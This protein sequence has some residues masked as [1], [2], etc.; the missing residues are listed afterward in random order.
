[1]LII[2]QGLAGTCLAWRLH[3]RGIPFLVVDRHE[4]LTSSKVAAGLVT[5]V[6]GMRLN[7]N[8]R[9]PEL[10]EEAVGLYRAL[11]PMLGA[12]FYHEAPIVRLL[13]DEKA[14]ALWEKRRVEPQI[15]PFLEQAGPGPLVDEARFHQPWGGFQM[16]HS[17]WLDAAGFVEASRQFFAACGSWQRGEVLPGE[18]DVQ[19]HAVEWAGRSFEAAV[20][21]IG[22]EAARHPWFDWVPF[23]SAQGTVLKLRADTGGENRILN[24]GC[25]LLPH[26][27]GLLRAGPTYDLKFKS[28]CEPA[29]DTVA[30][31]ED[32]LRGLFKGSWE[33]LG[34]QT[35]VRPIIQGRKALLGRHPARRRVAFLNGLG[36]KGVLRAPWAARVLVEHLLDG[37]PLDAGL[38]LAT[39]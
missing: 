8:W 10:H 30:A 33:V 22:W 24:R 27:D 39:A 35:G 14:A 3:Q 5:P 11:E 7:L 17:G 12:R 31:L 16:R 29:P 1:M 25:W 23:R 19:P 34:S 9:Y 37:A 32:K 4:A 26:S 18:L 15:L 28:P 2:G 36:S 6:T 38:D 21:C 20:F 13:R